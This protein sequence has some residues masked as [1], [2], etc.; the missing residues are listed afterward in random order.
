MRQ[1]RKFYKIFRLQNVE[2]LIIKNKKLW[3]NPCRDATSVFSEGLR[4]VEEEEWAHIHRLSIAAYSM[5]QIDRL[6]ITAVIHTALN[7]IDPL[8]VGITGTQHQIFLE[9]LS[10]MFLIPIRTRFVA[11]IRIQHDK[12]R[13]LESKMTIKCCYKIK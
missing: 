3:D 1:R 7:S 11:R 2:F 10:P 13:P 4:D 5:K 8:G 9:L 12:V 6:G